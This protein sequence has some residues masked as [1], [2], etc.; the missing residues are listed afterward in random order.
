LPA[1]ADVVVIGGGIVGVA[2]AYFLASKGRTVALVEKGRIAAEQSSRNWGWCRVQNRDLREVPLMRHS[3]ELWDSLPGKIGADLG[4]RRNGLIYVTKNR[5]ELAAWENWVEAARSFQV[6][7]R[8]LGPDEA[9]ALT[10]GNEQDWIGGVHSPRDGRAEPSLAAPGLAA[11][12]RRLGATIHQDCAVRGLDVIAGRVSGV[13]TERGR[14]ATDAVLCAAGAWSSMLCRR[15]GIDLPQAGV[16]STVFITA[17]APEVTPGGLA[18]PDFT[19]TRR[20]DGGYLIA[21][22]DRGRLEVT[23]QGLRYA[24]VFWPTFRSRR[25]SLRVGIGRSFL[26][27][28]EAPAGKWSFDKPTPFER[29]REFAPPPDLGIVEPALHRVTATYPA[30]Q[31]LRMARAWGGWIDSTPDAIPVISAVDRLPGFFLATGFSGHGFGI[32]PAAGRLAADLIT[33]DKP[34]VDPHPYRYARLVDGTDL[35]TPG[36][37]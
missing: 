33:G 6:E 23:L 10:P 37:M 2:A 28:P 8:M 34:V 24:R 4:F 14:I 26:Q 20:L 30:L 1:R 17:P 25:K 7:S 35:G 29:H 32:G 13:V 9:K 16:R 15:H 11:A 5:D 36:M 18:T 27:G 21:A 12:A 19:I 22:Q 3:M 31:G